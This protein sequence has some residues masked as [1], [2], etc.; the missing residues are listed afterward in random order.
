MKYHFV[1]SK[2]PFRGWVARTL[3]V[4]VLVVGV[5]AAVNQVAQADG[6]CSSGQLSDREV[7]AESW[8]PAAWGSSPSPVV[9]KSCEGFNTRFS[10]SVP[11]FGGL[12]LNG[13]L[14]QGEWLVRMSVRS[15]T[16]K[17]L[18]RGYIEPGTAKADD[19]DR[20]IDGDW[21]T[22]MF[23]VSVAASTSVNANIL[24]LGEQPMAL[25][26]ERVGVSPLCSTAEVPAGQTSLQS[27][28]VS[29]WVNADVSTFCTGFNTQHAAVLPQF[30]G[31]GLRQQQLS[32]G[33]WTVQFRARSLGRRGQVRVYVESNNQVLS[34][35]G[36]QQI[37]SSWTTQSI[38]F[39]M[40]TAGPVN[41]N[42]VSS[43]TDRLPVQI[44][45]LS[46]GAVCS[47]NTIPDGQIAIDSW[48]GST[49]KDQPAFDTSCSGYNTRRTV[50]L[51]QFDGIGFY[52]PSFTARNAYAWVRTTGGSAEVRLYTQ[53]GETPLD[54]ETRT[55]STNWEQL[56]VRA[57]TSGQPL[58]VHVQS[59]NAEPVTLEI[60]R[61]SVSEWTNPT[62]ATRPTTT[63]ATPTLAPPT[64]PG[65]TR[66]GDTRPGDTR[67]GEVPATQPPV[68]QPPVTQPPATQPPVTQPPGPVSPNDPPIASAGVNAPNAPALSSA[69]SPSV[70]AV[71]TPNLD[72]SQIQDLL[73]ALPG[74][75]QLVF[76]P[77]KYVGTYLVP[78][79][80]SG[81][82]SNPTVLRGEPGAVFGSTG[83][84]APFV[85]LD[86]SAASHVVVTGFTF[87]R[88]AN[89]SPYLPSPVLVL[90]QASVSNAPKGHRVTGNTFWQ[91]GGDVRGDGSGLIQMDHPRKNNQP[92]GYPGNQCG[93][94]Q[95]EYGTLIGIPQY[96]TRD[97]GSGSGFLIDSNTFDAVRASAVWINN[98]MSNIRVI[99]NTVTG[100]SSPNVD[101]I[102]RFGTAQSETY[103]TNNEFSWNTVREDARVEG[104]NHRGLVLKQN[105]IQVV[106]N[107]VE[108]HSWDIY[109]RSSTNATVSQNVILDSIV[110]VDGA[111]HL[112][113][114]NYVRSVD[115]TNKLSPITFGTNQIAYVNG[116]AYNGVA[117]PYWVAA[118]NNARVL[119]NTII[120]VKGAAMTIE[121]SDTTDW[122]VA[123]PYGLQIVGNRIVVG[124]GY[125]ALTSGRAGF[126]SAAEREAEILTA[127]TFAQN[128]LCDDPS[129]TGGLV[130]DRGAVLGRGNT[131]C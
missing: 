26:V 28:S 78:R 101:E 50:K 53:T 125:F 128:T 114:N 3:A 76:K 30:G 16:G 51:N 7:S 109:L 97:N 57:G 120:A 126:F 4:A 122:S 62:V 108:G 64:V 83:S 119:N 18:V 129:R 8:S 58:T 36:S 20:V 33:E 81:T 52:H 31:L 99:R 112:I 66:P 96:D 127:G 80:A 35:L 104:T 5:P 106:G 77:G 103:Y 12:G 113:Q 85:Q 110:R 19:G 47:T 37:D 69:P 73:N 130:A 54:I 90:S 70:S 116:V 105:G 48:P 86:L 102:F 95:Y 88:T 55:V 63:G 92:D 34:D 11:Q 93:S 61:W 29:A 2:N 67:P 74:G 65:D 32:A 42:V 118:P 98:G 41:L 39:L 84:D 68:T 107:L 21:T 40:I 1:G 117:A 87:G 121:R 59:A 13:N 25:E 43:E 15:T 23:P 131:I 75:S 79:S 17:A 24:S 60:E 71:V 45:Q 124:N 123:K 6:D 27:W 14:P 94:C 100:Q 89:P 72:Q 38:R 115:P 46:I 111:G 82:A 91:T 22:L 10:V 49:W 56:V 9:E 44:D